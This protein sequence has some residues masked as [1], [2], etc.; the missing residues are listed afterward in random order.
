M[1]GQYYFSFPESYD[2]TKPLPVLVGFHGCGEGNRGTDLESTEWMRLTENSAFKTEYVRA[3]PISAASGGCWDYGDDIPRTTAMTQTYLAA[4]FSTPR[5]F[6]MSKR[7]LSSSV[8]PSP[9]KRAE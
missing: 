1:S 6:S 4:R 9:A 2:G 3:V 8:A 7:L 5:S